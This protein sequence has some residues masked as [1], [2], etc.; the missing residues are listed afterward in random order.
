[1]PQTIL[2]IDD[3]PA[4]LRAFFAA[5]YS[6]RVEAA[7]TI[8]SRVHF[9]AGGFHLVVTG[10]LSEQ[11]RHEVFLARLT[12]EGQGHS[13]RVATLA[14]NGYRHMEL[15]YAVSGSGAVLHTL[16]FVIACFS[17][18]IHAMRLNLLEFFGKFYE[19]G[20]KMFSPFR[21][22][23]KNLVLGAGETRQEGGAAS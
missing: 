15:Y 4:Q 6:D 9:I 14:W 22:R 17:P 5:L 3:D 20:G 18:F 11:E 10:K 21:Y 23:T 12:G 13:D 7:S 19:G 1:M 2:S 8:N 16:N